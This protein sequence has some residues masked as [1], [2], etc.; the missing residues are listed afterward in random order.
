M[1]DL[2][3][4]ECRR[5][6]NL[7]IIGALVHLML[8]LLA[9]RLTEPLMQRWQPQSLIPALHALAA[10]ALAVYQFGTHRQ[11]SRWVWL[12]HR[13]LPRG[14]IFAA[15][16]L[17]AL[18]VI[19]VVIGLPLLLS[20]AGTDRLSGRTVDLRHY[21][22]VPYCVLVAANAWLA[23]TY[24]MLCGRR[25][26]CVV[27]AVPFILMAHA[28]SAAS[29]LLPGLLSVA[30]MT[31]LAYSTFAPD[32]TAPPRGAA[33]MA[34]AALPLVL[35]C[36]FVLL[37]GGSLGFQ[38]GQMLAGVHPLNRAVPPAGG[39]TELVRSDSPANL[40]RMLA[41]S[42]DP[43]AAHWRR[44]VA[45]SGSASVTPML[46]AHPVRQELGNSNSLQWS[47]GEL[48]IIWSFNH[49]RM[50]YEGR[51]MHTD[52]PRGW[53]G[54]GGMNDPRPFESVPV[55]DGRFISTRHHLVAHEDYSR[56][57]RTLLALP[58]TETLAGRTKEI[59][60]LQFL[61]T[62]RR[63][64][65][66]REPVDAAAPLEEVYSVALPGPF[67]DL[68]RVDV[69]RLLDGTLL[70]FD[71]GRRMVDGQAGSTQQLVF[72]DA[73]GKAHTIATRTLGHDFPLLFEHKAW[74]L[75]PLCHALLSLPERLLD[76]GRIED[77][78]ASPA[79][80][81]PPAIIAAALLA[82]LLSGGFAWWRLRDAAPRSRA[83]W[84]AAALLLGPP[85]VACLLIL[86]PQAAHPASAR[87]TAVEHRSAMPAAA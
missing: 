6:R 36:Y 31:A 17:A 61:L 56:R 27:L 59:G 15:L 1:K 83:A 28:S 63:L 40:Q 70:S 47:D 25:A 30:V 23:G 73:A 18:A 39:Y 50:M 4:A 5:F 38:Y 66:Y 58:A 41:A 79:S 37:W 75:S 8:L 86:R 29:L 34:A 80:A 19:V 85:C 45:L 3:F 51:D 32:R 22:A 77:A 20:I 68:A 7:A 78:A 67:S 52:A 33:G 11:P 46:D 62:N 14:R 10:L 84:S 24:L 55:M 53:Y 74:W 69:A 44:Q 26:A 87:P 49:D 42:S 9:S 48:K 81:R 64:V 60:M 16:A 65:A 71:F 35:G 82:A 76:T 57:T 13:P 12:L 72:V 2:F 54:Q 21:L 43:R